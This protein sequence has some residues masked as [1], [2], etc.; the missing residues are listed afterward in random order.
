[1]QDF[2]IEFLKLSFI[3]GNT[4]FFHVTIKMSPPTLQL[5]IRISHSPHSVTWSEV[6]FMRG[7]KEQESHAEH[8]TPAPLGEYSHQRYDVE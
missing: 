4:C 2:C 1:M 3:Q 5:Q 7:I 6:T 8:L